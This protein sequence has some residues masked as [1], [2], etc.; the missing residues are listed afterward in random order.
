MPDLPPG[1]A[2]ALAAQARQN[3]EQQLAMQEHH[4]RMQTAENE[5]NIE[6]RRI[7]LS[8]TPLFCTCRM[9]YDRE[10]PGGTRGCPVHSALMLHYKTGEVIT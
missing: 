7:L 4:E 9:G 10:D 3:H 6:Q 8:W 2:E 1:V 5:L